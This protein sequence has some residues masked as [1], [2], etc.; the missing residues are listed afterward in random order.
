MISTLKK[1][2][3]KLTEHRPSVSALNKNNH[4]EDYS[5]WSVIL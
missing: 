2:F 3:I 4:D 5:F 1:I